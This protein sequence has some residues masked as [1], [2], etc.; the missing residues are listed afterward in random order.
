M[1]EIIP[2]QG[3]VTVVV[4]RT[5]AIAL[6]ADLPRPLLAV[7]PNFDNWND[8]GRQYFAGFVAIGAENV[9]MEAHFRLMVEGRLSTATALTD[10]LGDQDIV[11]IENLLP[12]FVSLLPHTDQYGELVATLGFGPAISA[13]RVLGDAV[14][15]NIEESDA[16]LLE[17]TRSEDFHLGVLRPSGAYAALLRGARYFRATPPPEVEDA[18]RSFTF[19]TTLPS[20]DNEYS[21]AF[22]FDEDPIFQDRAAVLIGKNGAGKT[23]LLQSIVGGLI[24]DLV[25]QDVLDMTFDPAIQVSRVLVFS[26]VPNDPFPKRIGAWHGIDYEHFAISAQDQTR[27]DG[28]LAALASCLRADRGVQFGDDDND[29]GRMDLVKLALEPLGLWHRLHV[30]LTT[31]ED[32]DFPHVVVV[33]DQS[34]F[35]VRRNLN[36]Q[37]SL[38]LIQRLDWSRSLVVFGEEGDFRRL[39]SGEMAMLRLAIQ[40]AASIEPGCLL[41]LDEP[42]N[43]LHPNYVSQAMNLLHQVLVATKSIAIIATHSAYV[44][45]EVPRQRVHILT[46]NDREITIA[47]PR[48]QTFGASVDTISQFVFGDTSMDHR[49]QHALE[50]W[51][52]TTGREIG[53]DQVIADYGQDLNPESLSLIASTI[54]DADGD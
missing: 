26:S 27:T 33:G 37:N 10:A 12:D 5:Q 18:A 25:G 42:E 41:L 1:P 32:D 16:H 6:A 20:A 44:V 28:T 54:R 38:K 46:L 47:S 8:Y 22:D 17:L 7:F 3:H 30:P 48:L 19:S 49:F 35:A 52:L 13:M 39:S 29:V 21:I 50:K 14:V 15:L 36:E 4:A 51:A 23:M 45:R 9:S 24:D 2:A 11:P 53:I 31:K 34:F 40:M 43:H